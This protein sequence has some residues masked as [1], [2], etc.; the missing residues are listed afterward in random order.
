[1]PNLEK[2]IEAA[3][4]LLP[5][6]DTWPSLPLG[7]RERRQAVLDDIARR[8]REDGPR[9]PVNDPDRGRLFMPFAALKGYDE[10]TAEA[11]ET[12]GHDFEGRE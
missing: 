6:V 9:R 12:V 11:E 5:D 3:I 7:E 1:M 10:L 8:I 4:A 2:E